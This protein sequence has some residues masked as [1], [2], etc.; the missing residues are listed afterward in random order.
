[1][2]VL[3]ALILGEDYVWLSGDVERIFKQGANK[4]NR[5]HSPS[6]DEQRRHG[7][8][9]SILGTAVMLENSR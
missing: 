4:R 6:W 3:G 5:V 1:M 7:A 2:G 9:D 8:L